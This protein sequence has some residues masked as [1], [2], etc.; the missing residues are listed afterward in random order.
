MDV[1]STLDDLS[2][3]HPIKAGQ[4]QSNP[5]KTH[6]HDTERL[7]V[8]DDSPSPKMNISF[9]YGWKFKHTFS[10]IPHLLQHQ[11]EFNGL[12]AHPAELSW[13]KLRTLRV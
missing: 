12:V 5:S 4:R 10:L 1:L 11:Q 13:L 2:S 9:P 6:T 8:N 7:P 3:W